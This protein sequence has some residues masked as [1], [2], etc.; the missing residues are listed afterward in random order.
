MIRIDS[1][2]QV[3]EAIKRVRDFKKGY[4]TNFFIDFARLDLWIKH[5]LLYFLDLNSTIFFFKK[6]SSFYNVYYS[7]I[8]LESLSESLYKTK[9][10]YSNDI[11]VYDIVGEKNKLIDQ[12]K[13]FNANGFNLY[14]SLIRMSRLIENNQE[15]INNYG[16]KYAKQT[17]LT[18]V[19]KLLYEYFDIYAE[20]LPEIYDLKNWIINNHI[21]I[22]LE[23]VTII[24][25]LIFDL[26]GKTSYLRYWFV[27]PK[28][29]NKKV[30]SS[31]LKWYFYESN[32]TKRQHFWVIESNENAIKR[33]RHYGFKKENLKDYVFININKH[34]EGESNR[35]IKG[36]P[37]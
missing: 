18:E 27:H 30:G 37:A 12:V 4:Y 9:S 14:T 19:Y 28:H 8:S 31:L 21:L 11:F 1:V 16:L 35:N 32:N 5:D 29:R 26:V 10:F 2:Q 33:Y 25:F 6:N 20:Q 3:Q 23:N 17:D 7:S 15:K 13:V 22:Y 36:N 24:G 34:Y